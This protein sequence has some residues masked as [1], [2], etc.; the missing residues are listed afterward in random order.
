MLRA[1]RADRRGLGLDTDH[2]LWRGTAPE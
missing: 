1:Q 2:P